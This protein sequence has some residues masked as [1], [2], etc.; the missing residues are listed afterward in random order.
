MSI[1]GRVSRPP[2]VDQLRKYVDVFI[3]NNY[4][5]DIFTDNSH[6]WMIREFPSKI[7]NALECAN[8]R[9]VGELLNIEVA[10][11]K[12]IPMIGSVS[13]EIIEQFKEQYKHQN[14]QLELKHES[15]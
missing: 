13:I 5:E 11:L 1:T 2:R 14:R 4:D 3:F 10:M 9:T 12:R 8:I 6:I 15:S 7:V